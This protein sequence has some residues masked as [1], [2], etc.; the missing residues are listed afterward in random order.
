MG[1]KFELLAIYIMVDSLLLLYLALS[2]PTIKYQ[3]AFPVLQIYRDNGREPLVDYHPMPPVYSM[4]S[5]DM[6]YSMPP[7]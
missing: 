6:S 3:E 1:I 4:V 7:V 5:H 2:K